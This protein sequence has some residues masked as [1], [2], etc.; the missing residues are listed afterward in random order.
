[1]FNY[2]LDRK[3]EITDLKG[4]TIVNLAKSIFS[5]GAS[6]VRDYD[7]YK[8]SD[9]CVMRPDLVSIAMYGDQSH[10]EY[11]LKYA[12]I[13]NPFTLCKDDVLL[14][15]NLSQ[16]EGMMAANN[17]RAQEEIR[18]TQIAQIRNFFKF[19]NQEYKSDQS[20]Y[21]KLENMKIPSAVIDPSGET[22]Y[23]V[24]YITEDGRTSVTIRNGRVYFGEDT[25]IPNAA[26]TTSTTEGITNSVQ[27]LIDKAISNLSDTNCL[28]NGTKLTDLFRANAVQ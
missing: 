16:A 10:A 3:E 15:P 28:Y 25:G 26:T 1:M 2:S 19:V 9:Y 20:S 17:E 18:Q 24:P 14:V 27:S 5:D 12:G 23:Y 21:D 22:D 6:M 11:I 7:I 8:A 4:N 13:S